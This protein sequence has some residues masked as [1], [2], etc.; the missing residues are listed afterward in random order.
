L[1]EI[2]FESLALVPAESPAR[3]GIYEIVLDDQ[4]AIKELSVGKHSLFHALLFLLA[5]QSERVSAQ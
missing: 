5:Q 4:K 1:K 2:L 3:V